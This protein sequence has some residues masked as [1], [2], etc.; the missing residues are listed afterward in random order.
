MTTVISF[1]QRFDDMGLSCLCNFHHN[2]P[3]Y[4]VYNSSIYAI[5]TCIFPGCKK[6]PWFGGSFI[7]GWRTPGNIQGKYNILLDFA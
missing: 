3:V 1:T 5:D 7:A 4:L 6:Y 2:L